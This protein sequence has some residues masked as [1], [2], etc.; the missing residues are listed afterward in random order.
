MRLRD[1]HRVL[2][3]V[4]GMTTDGSHTLRVSSPIA[5]VERLAGTAQTSSGRVYALCGPPAQSE[6][7]LKLLAS[8]L[9]KCGHG[10]AVDATDTFWRD[11]GNL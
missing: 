10:D 7:M 8:W 1:G 3:G 4:V 6:R 5:A 11:C 9:A 2:V